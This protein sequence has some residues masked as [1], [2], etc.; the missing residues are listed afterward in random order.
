MN[1][2]TPQYMS[3]SEFAAAQGWVP[4]YVSKL[5]KQGRLVLT[6]DGRVDVPATLAKMKGTAD[7]SKEGVRQRHEQ[8]RLERGVHQ[9][10]R[11]GAP[12]MEPP[13]DQSPRYHDFQK[14]RARREHYLAEQAELEYKKLC[15]ELVERG[16]VEAA[17]ERLGRMLRDSVLGV[18]TKL[19]PKV[20]AESDPWTVEQTIRAALRAALDDIAKLTAEDLQR[21]LD[22]G[23]H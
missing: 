13:P 2:E 15:G 14:A 18:A 4:S 22:E 21:A 17:A 8:E 10:L 3:K 11:P 20:A 16:P 12:D 23:L 5:N 7:P 6:A 19:A 9:H 1:G